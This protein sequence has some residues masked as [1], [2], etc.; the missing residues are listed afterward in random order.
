M[1]EL[2]STEILDKEIEADARNKAA[3]ILSDADAECQKLLDAVADRIKE[4]TAQKTAYYDAKIAAFKKNRDAALPLE[5]ERYRVSFYVKSVAD[6]YNDYFAKLGDEKL[7]SLI[8]PLLV[9]SKDAL[10]GKKVRAR[11]FGFA[12]GDAKKLVE[13]HCGAKNVLS[14][15]ETTFELSGDEAVPLND[16]HKGIILESEDNAVRC[17]LTTDQLVGELTDRYSAE[18]ATTLFGG[19]LPQ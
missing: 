13:K 7:L 15:A 5:Q 16:V 11:V 3:R 4:A 14:C 8:E 17:R 12:L 18:L 10:A 9:R 19:R 1:E 6:A 2:R